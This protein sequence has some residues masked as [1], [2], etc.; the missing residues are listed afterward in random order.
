MK[1][2]RRILFND[3]DHE[4]TAYNQNILSWHYTC[5]VYSMMVER[6]S[7]GRGRVVARWPVDSLESCERLPATQ[8]AL[9]FNTVRRDHQKRNYTLDVEEA[10]VRSFMLIQW[11]KLAS[12]DRWTIFMCDLHTIL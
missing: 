9:T 2:A 4:K 11:K 10:Q 8:I 5:L 6:E 1:V 3:I 7:G 12:F